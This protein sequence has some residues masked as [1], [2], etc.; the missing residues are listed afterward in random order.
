MNSLIIFSIFG[1][2]LILSFAFALRAVK[3][4]LNAKASFAEE[5]SDGVLL[6]IKV[7]RQ[8]EKGPLAA[9]MM[10]SAMHGL[11]EEGENLETQPETHLSFEITGSSQGVFF[12]T[13]VPKK[14]K[15][16]VESQIYAQYPA[17]EIKEIE[18]YSLNLPSAALSATEIVLSREYYFPLKTFAD[19][20]VDPLAAITSAVENLDEEQQVWFQFLVKP[21]PD[22][23]KK[24]GVE[25]VEWLRSGQPAP[26][27]SLFAAIRD[28]FFKFGVEMLKNVVS[29]I[30]T[31]QPPIAPLPGREA[32]PPRLSPE[33][34]ND[35]KGIQQKLTSLGFEVGMR[36]LGFGK[37]QEQAILAVDALSAA[38]RQYSKQNSFARS[39]FVRDFNEVL[40]DFRAR[41]MPLERENIFILTA[42]ELA[43]IFHLPNVSV[44]TPNIAWTKAKKS[45][46]PLELPLSTPIKI[47]KTAFR[48]QEVTFGIKT[49]DR[50]RH[51]YIIGKT[52][53][54]KTTLMRNMVLQDM[55]AG[56]GLAVLDPHGDFFEY[57]LENIPA[58][59]VEDVV[60]M[61]PSDQDFPVALNMLEMFDPDQRSLLASGLVDV[62]KARF[63]FSW[64]P[65]ME[66]LLRNILL[67]LLEVPG[68]T[69]LSV[70]RILMDRAY[71]RYVVHILEDPVTRQFWDQ[72]FKEMRGNQRLVTEAIAPI[73]NRIGQFLASPVIRN[74]V[75]QAKSTIALDEIMDGGKILLVNLSKGKIG[76]DNSAILGSMLISRLQFAA[77]MRARV[78]EEERRDFHVY[79]DEFQNFATANFATILSEARKYRLNLVLAHQ[80]I[81]QIPEEVRDA[82][83][84]NV[85]TFISFVCG[86]SDAHIL[87]REFKPVFLENDLMNLEKYHIY[88]RLMI[89]LTQSQPFS[90]VTLA[91][92]G[93]ARS[94]KSEVVQRSREKYARPREVVEG[95][96]S[97]WSTKQFTPGMDDK[98]VAALREEQKRRGQEL[99]GEAVE[100]SLPPEVVTPSQPNELKGEIKLE[101]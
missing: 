63:A 31:A 51:I 77:M 50:R 49:D 12:Y 56:Q 96:V 59:R 83:F 79:A 9:E 81:A 91:P 26:P 34:E 32:P 15:N 85:G 35:V 18:D 25:Y 4:R 65:R 57:I 16:F 99:R 21:A 55:Q 54:G 60:V 75:G 73:Q 88:L 33:Q 52:G 27:P 94:S 3:R 20:E 28:S 13:F 48:G 64:G 58:H 38:L 46:P 40:A 6:S 69:L 72:E 61:D 47:A 2:I 87:E 39:G 90:A 30:L 11:M 22:V 95:R 37:T 93:Q 8:N 80:Y 86:Q 101:I 66:H 10:F 62:F 76:D 92:M 89:D 7:P 100:L 19:F 74:I 5:I 78:S 36:V 98:V 41:A 42:T 45:E 23:W 29:G 1:T 43:S 17:A 71:E 14:Q 68:A 44:E 97:A 53:T 82:V 24:P 70:P 67:T 84:G